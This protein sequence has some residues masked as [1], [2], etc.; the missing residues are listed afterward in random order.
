MTGRYDRPCEHV[1]DVL[2][3]IE[4]THRIGD[5]GTVLAHALRDV[6]LAHLEVLGKSRV[7]GGFF[8][9]VEVLALEIL[10][11]RH[12]EHITITGL[13]DY[14]RNFS[15]PQFPSS[16]ES[17]L[18][19]DQFQ[20]AFHLTDDQRLNDAMLTN[21]IDQ[22]GQLLSQELCSRLQGAGHHLIQCHPTDHITC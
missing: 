21:R 5:R 12:L 18:T 2:R 14:D 16:T 4:Q 15:E 22:L 11:E 8:N 6:F 1:L 19:G 10:N 13:T 20:G 9:G 17:T 3:Q 7:G